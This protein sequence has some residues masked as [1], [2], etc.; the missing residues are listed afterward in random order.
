MVDSNENH[1]KDLS[2]KPKIK[3]II[4]IKGVVTVI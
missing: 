4:Q 1:D 2:P 3:Y